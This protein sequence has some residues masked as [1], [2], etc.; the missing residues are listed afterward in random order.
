MAS[1]SD[2]FGQ[3]RQAAA[4]QGPVAL[5]DTLIDQLRS[6]KQY[7]QLFEALRMRSRCRLGLPPMSRDEA[8][9]VGS[10]GFEAFEKALLEA[11]REVGLLLLE[12]GRI[13]E[14]W[15]YLRPVG[16]TV[17]VVR[18]L[19]RLDV[20][21]DQLEEVIEIL[22]GE[23]VDP[24][25]GLSLVLDRYGT[26]N[27][28]TTFESSFGRFPRS[29]QRAAVEMLVDH[30][31]RELVASLAHHVCERE[32]R[33]PGDAT[34]AELLDDRSWLFEGGAYHID[35]SHLA[36]TIRFSRMLDEA[37]VLTKALHMTT[38]GR[39]LDSQYQF[40]DAEPF[41]DIYPSHALFLDA[42][43]GHKVEQAV[44]FFGQKAADLDVDEHGSLPTETYIDLLKRVGRSAEAVEVLIK[45]A[46]RY[47]RAA[48]V[49]GTLLELCE[50]AGCMD[51]YLDFCQRHHQLLGFA[52]G[53]LQTAVDG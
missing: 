53:L 2:N 6:S 29:Q 47:D 38:Y 34:L 21:D 24:P 16:D 23:G 46:E 51:R 9:S 35:P 49:V 31:H 26:C 18:T 12:D 40:P 52:T 37:S 48:D 41:V 8:E 36:A 15:N 22:I 14:G 27:A 4:Q 32:G 42:L 5:L 19:E 3:L 45:F 39:R 17:A 13:R 10:P 30:V 1:P 25:R 7:H 44:A 28:I 43:L 33:D 50:D 11:C 20:S